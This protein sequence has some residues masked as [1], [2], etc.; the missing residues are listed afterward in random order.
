MNLPDLFPEADMAAQAAVRSYCGWHIAPVV[1]ETVFVNG[2]GG[3]LLLLPTLKLVS[4]TTVTNDGAAVS[5]PEWSENGMIRH[6]GWSRKLRGVEVS[7]THG[8]EECPDDIRAVVGRLKESLAAPISVTQQS[9]GPFGVT[10]A[11]VGPL[12]PRRGQELMG[13][14]YVAAVLDRYKLPSRP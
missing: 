14:T 11:A 12:D 8:F 3:H 13:D 7:F 10:Y 5:D 9:T 1:A 4:V 2:P 6:C